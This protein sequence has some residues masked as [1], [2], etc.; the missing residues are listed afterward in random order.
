MASSNLVSQTGI[1]S[2]PATISGVNGDIITSGKVKAGFFEFPDQTTMSTAAHGGSGGNVTL[3]PL[4]VKNVSGDYTIVSGDLNNTYLRVQA[5]IDANVNVTI[6]N[7]SSLSCDIGTRLLLCAADYGY[8]TIV[9][10]SGVYVKSPKTTTIGRKTGRVQIIKTDTNQWEVDGQ[11]LDGGPT[12]PMPVTGPVLRGSVNGHLTFS[13]FYY[14]AMT[15]MCHNGLEPSAPPTSPPV[16]YTITS[17]TPSSLPSGVTWNSS[18]GSLSISGPAV[19]AH[20]TYI[21]NFQVSDQNGSGDTC[22]CT[23]SYVAA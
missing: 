19:G 16:T 13:K 5:N 14:Q 12:D 22:T 21:I 2:G 1:T 20:T 11:L 15:V 10:A 9:G 8:V 7:A 6:P 23:V 17:T 3:Q 4:S 18:T